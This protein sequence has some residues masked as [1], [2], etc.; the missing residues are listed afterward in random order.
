MKLSTPLMY[1]GNPRSAAPDTPPVEFGG[2]VEGFTEGPAEPPT[3][4]LR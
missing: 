2:I 1:D 4:D 3:G